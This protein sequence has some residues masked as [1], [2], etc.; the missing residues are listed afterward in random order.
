MSGKHDLLQAGALQG[1][2]DSNDND[3]YSYD[4]ESPRKQPRDLCCCSC[5]PKR[6][7][8][9]ILSFFGFVNV[10]ALRVNL[11]V[12]LVAMVSN[13]TGHYEN[14]T[15]YVISPPEFD[16]DSRLRGFILSAFFYGYI[17][18]QI[19]GGWLAAKYGGK[20]LFGCGILM[21]ALFTL[22]TPPA[23]RTNVYLLVVIRMFE[24]LFEGVTFPC[25][26]AIW[27]KWAPPME[28]SKLATISFSGPFAG[29]VLGMP[30]SGLIADNFGW[31]WVFYSFGLMAIIWSFFWF[32]LITDSPKDQPKIS[33][34]ELEY[35]QSSLSDDKPDREMVKTPWKDIFKSI[36]VWAIIVAHTTENWGWYTLLTQ[37]P[38][39]LKQVLNFSLKEA[40]FISALPYLAMVIVVQAG[41]RFADFL[42]AHQIMRTTVVRKVFNSIG[43]FSQAAFLVV[44][45]YTT[46]KE[47]AIVGLTLAVGLGGF[48]WSGFPVN[49]LDIS[50]RYASILFGIS[51]CIATLPGI[52]SPMMVGFITENETQEEWRVVFL[53]S[54]SVYMFGLIFY[55]IFASGEKQ[56]WADDDTYF[57][58]ETHEM[59]QLLSP[60]EGEKF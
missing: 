58:D 33:P 42:R 10:Y 32:M 19:P 34:E 55:A 9:A 57:A 30:L 48:T 16:W 18:T 44:V 23:A 35:I 46:S 15:A 51:N 59:D 38:T 12:A 37:L 6:Y 50:P 25:I 28:R 45:G 21:T 14:G 5:L 3:M 20:N 36:P 1:S 22:I 29:T 27:R 13:T 24:G 7:L 31:P 56:P 54:A 53:I 4:E 26:H 11:S 60:E 8:V 2:S 17:V 41:G 47:F 40:G 52:F 49:H 39:Y 43:F